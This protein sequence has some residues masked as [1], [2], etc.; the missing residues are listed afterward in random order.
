MRGVKSIFST[1]SISAFTLLAA[2]SLA[3]SAVPE[4][5]AQTTLTSA[6]YDAATGE[7]VVTGTNMAIGDVIAVNKLTLTGEGTATYALTTPNVMASSATAFTITLNAADKAAVNQIINKNGTN[8]TGGT[9]YNLAAA[10]DWDANVTAGDI[11]DAINAVT[12]SN[13]LIS[14]TITFGANPGPRATGTMFV[15]YVNATG[16]ASGNPIVFTS[17]TPG[18]CGILISNLADPRLPGIC[19]I[20]ANQA[21]NANYRVAPQATQDIVIEPS[22]QTITFG[23]NPGPVNFSAGGTFSVT[24]TAYSN[25]GGSTASLTFTSLTTGVCTVSAR[26]VSMVTPGTCTIA[27]NSPGNVNISPAPQVT[28]DIVIDA[29]TQT[30]TFGANPSP[31]EYVCCA[32]PAF[33][34]NATGGA[35]GNP[36]T[37]TSLTP[38]VCGA[39]PYIGGYYFASVGICTIAANQA[40][41]ASYSAAPQVTEDIVIIKRNQIITFGANPGPVTLSP[42]G[43]PFSII[44][45]VTSMFG[46]VGS[47]AFSTITASICTVV[48]NTVTTVTAGI[49][50]IAANIGGDRNYNAAPQATQS[51]IINGYPQ[52]VV[53]GVAPVVVVG[54]VGGIFAGGSASGIPVTFASL[55]PAVCTIVGST[56]TGVTA[57]TCTIA[58][59]QAGSLYYEPAP[60]ATLSFNIVSVVTLSSVV[61]RK[62]HNGIDRD[63]VIDHLL[64]IGGNLSTEPRAIGAGHR[65]VFQ[66]SGPINLP[67]FPGAVDSGMFDIG[68]TS[69]AINPLANNEV[70]VT[71]TGVPDNKRVT[72]TLTNVNG[73][74]I[75]FAASMGFLVGDVNGSRTINASDISA[76]K[77]R[78]GQSTD[79]LNFKFDANASGTVNSSDISAVKA[80]S[81]LTLAP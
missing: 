66:F 16:G 55:T 70:I 42:I 19:I 74:V 73:I 39:A 45:T 14:Q 33:S 48:G 62:P 25:F 30:I 54:G 24:A 53:F 5:S 78:S 56:V 6:T 26:I 59:N 2:L 80:R 13:V 7:L 34:V 71:L 32:L 79:A 15:F 61:S 37:F 67:G 44:A 35:S 58:G 60:Q 11:S 47:I 63:I 49:C 18:V 31:V 40:G 76:V 28:Q 64:A 3:L 20:A 1:A 12:A 10:D 81:G 22:T 4:A 51:I 72:V 57:G 27:A 43:G 8:S 69:T 9:T 77:A 41:N 36:V 29:I 68:S 46:Q 75:P 17:L 65:I 21:G 23:A 52:S 38:S 50:V